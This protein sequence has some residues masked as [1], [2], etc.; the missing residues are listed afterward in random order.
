MF[1]DLFL[2]KTNIGR[3]RRGGANMVTIKI[4]VPE[5]VIGCV[6]SF[7]GFSFIITQSLMSC[8]AKVNRRPK[9]LCILIFWFFLPSAGARLGEE[10]LII[11]RSG[12]AH[13]ALQLAMCSRAASAKLCSL[14]RELNCARC[15]WSLPSKFHRQWV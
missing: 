1:S 2:R 10:L 5:D 3:L 9:N 7:L 8:S 6:Q 15:T 11:D 14:S 13:A 12:S 4:I